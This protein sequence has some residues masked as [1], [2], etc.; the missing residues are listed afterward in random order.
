[1]FVFFFAN[2]YKR[3]HVVDSTTVAPIDVGAASYQKLIA[4]WKERI[5]TVGGPQAYQEN[6]DAIRNLPRTVQHDKTH[7]FGDALFGALGIDGISVCDGRF[8]YACFHAFS[9]AGIQDMGLGNIEKMRDACTGA[10]S[11]S[12]VFECYHGIG[13]GILGSIA[14]SPFEYTERELQK[15]LDICHS[16]VPGKG[17]TGGVFMEYNLRSMNSGHVNPRPFEEKYAVEPCKRVGEDMSSCVYWLPMW[18]LTNVLRGL[19]IGFRC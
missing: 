5:E 15:A 10:L 17:C 16:F 12:T 9:I 8:S 2:E 14:S 11:Q 18:S 4:H 13:H 6:A 3:Y 19:P 7:V 1:V